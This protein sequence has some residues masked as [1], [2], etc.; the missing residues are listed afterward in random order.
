MEIIGNIRNPLLQVILE[1]ILQL[2]RKL[3]TGRST[4]NNNLGNIDS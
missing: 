1:E 3:N 2:C 4:S